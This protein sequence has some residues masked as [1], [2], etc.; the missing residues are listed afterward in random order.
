MIHPGKSLSTRI[1][2]MDLLRALAIIMV[3]VAHYPKSEGG[4]ITRVLNF[5][6]TGVDLFF[7]LSGYLIAG[8]LF[9]PM[10]AGEPLALGAFFLRRFLRTLPS[11]YAVL[12][13]YLLLVP[14]GAPGM[15]FLFFAQNFGVPEAFAPSWSLCVEEQ[16]YLLFPLA[17]LMFYRARRRDTLLYAVP[18]LLVLEIAV[19]SA[20]W[21]IHR[22]DLLREP[23]ALVSYMGSL[24]YPT[25]CRLDGIILGA[26][27]AALKYFRPA[28]WSSLTG[29]GNRLLTASGVCLIAAIVT[30]WRHYSFL[31]ST[32]GF[33][34]LNLSF[35]LLTAGALSRNGLLTRVHI[36]GA[37]Y[38]ALR[39]YALYLTHSLAIAAVAS[40]A[41]V[42][43]NLF[44]P[45]PALLL[46]ALL[47]LIFANLLYHV[48]ERPSLRL[49]DRLLAT[50]GSLPPVYPEQ[51]A[52]LRRLTDANPLSS[53]ES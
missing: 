46:T 53:Y 5:G 52:I 27:L 6:W 16:F 8:Q 45:I 30:L 36:P 14:G 25:Y 38:I 10:A 11:Y 39:S 19:R 18:A 17:L 22:P 32:I 24:Y 1:S 40:E 13:I 48:V 23:Q 44:Q 50:S 33:T 35:A 49:R 21:Y 31:C 2:S 43:P 28:T 47:S 37:K 51:A 29:H 9:K 3:L 26:G 7:V 42:L 34:C 41:R 20:V 15:R 12:A 4:L